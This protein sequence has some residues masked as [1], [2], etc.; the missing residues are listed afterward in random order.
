[1]NNVKYIDGKGKIVTKRATQNAQTIMG[2]G[3]RKDTYKPARFSVAQLDAHMYAQGYV[4]LK[5]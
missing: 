3:E 4:R 1:M 5:P 2:Y